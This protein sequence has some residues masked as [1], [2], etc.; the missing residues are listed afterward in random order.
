MQQ[1]FKIESA[2]PVKPNIIRFHTLMYDEEWNLTGEFEIALDIDPYVSYKSEDG[3][4][5]IDV[6][7]AAVQQEITNQIAQ[8][9]IT[10]YIAN[11]FTGLEWYADDDEEP[12][13]TT[14]DSE[15]ATE[16]ELQPS[17]SEGN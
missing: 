5:N 16:D 13:V 9:Q 3:N 17:L 12:E 2:R 10:G 1:N 8:M 7:A 14:D 6:N 15:T 4:I 11:G